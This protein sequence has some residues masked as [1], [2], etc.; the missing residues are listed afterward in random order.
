MIPRTIATWQSLSWQEELSQL[1]TDP[2]SLLDL[3]QLD[4][5][6]LP[7]AKKAAEEFPLRTTQSFARRIEPGNIADPLLRQILPIEH[8]L[9]SPAEFSFDP[10]AETRSTPAKGLIHKYEGRVLLIAASQCAI[11][12]RYC[13]RRHFDYAGNT[14]SRNE[15]K[16]ALT[17]IQS[18]SSIEEVILSG[19][20][21]LALADKQ[22]EWLINEIN[23]IPH[24]TRLRIHTRLPIVL[25]SRM[26]PTLLKVLAEQALPTVM[27]VHCNHA[28]EIDDEVLRALSNVSESGITLLNQTVLLKGVNDCADSLRDLSK[29]LFTAKAL[30]Y[31]LHILDKVKG[32]AHFYVNEADAT[33]L[34]RQLLN[35][36]PG[37]LV[38]KLVKEVPDEPSKVPINY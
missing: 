18:D 31:Y 2:K 7:Q 13:F 15:W 12:C 26:T 25:P 5:S 27:V 32:A 17:Y 19:G 8:E 36:L 28:Q 35:T 23:Q 6:L 16:E 14:P 38:P 9:S 3:L 30:P 10:L 29:R 22:L 21:P 34:H 11:N 37:Y 33:A 1:I 4:E 24:I 20:D